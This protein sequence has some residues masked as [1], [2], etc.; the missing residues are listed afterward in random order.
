M[1]Q[2]PSA[3]FVSATLIMSGC[4]TV[5]TMPL[6]A[7]AKTS[8]QNQ[9][10]TISATP[11]ASFSAMTAL[12]V[13]FGLMGALVALEKGNRLIKENAVEDP[14]LQIAKNLA[15][16][17]N[18][19]YQVTV[20]GDVVFA[21]DS[22][23]KLAAART[24]S[25]YLLTVSTTNWGSVYFPSALTSYRVIYKVHARLIDISTQKVISEASCDPTPKTKENAPSWDQLTGNSAEGLKKILASYVAQC[26]QQMSEGMLSQ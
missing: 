12:N 22:E 25:K 3:L 18:E 23:A 4:A 7:T 15:Q 17:L 11:K 19:K 21:T 8:L 2:I 20:S 13:Q 1:R 16:D 26:S 14:A 24:N 10:A 5:K 9:M 6:S